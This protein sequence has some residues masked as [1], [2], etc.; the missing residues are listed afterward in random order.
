M[1]NSY[2]KNKAS[3]FN[4]SANIDYKILDWLNYQLV[5]SLSQSTN[6]ME[7]FLGERTST[8]EMLYRGYPVGGAEP[9][10]DLF[11]A[12]LLPFGGQLTTNNSSMLSLN[13]QHKLVASKTFNEIHRFN[14]M[15]GMEVRSSKSKGK[16]NN[17][18][19]FVPERG[20]SLVSPSLPEDVTP[21]GGAQ[22]IGWG[23]LRQLFEGGWSSTNTTS[24]YMSFFGTFAYS[25]MNR[26]V[27][28]MNIRSDASNR[29]GQD[30]NKQFDPT[31]SFGIS[32]KIAEEKFIKDHVK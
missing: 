32:W 31:Y 27:V 20:E 28:N 26:Y 24:N 17:V 14:M 9:G 21:I 30:G 11:K 19:G 7:S 8:I 1:D 2:S 6:D 13:M 12:A 4:A 18:W 3:T 10:S 22:S 16:A 23:A 15:L 29:F 25:L 5:G